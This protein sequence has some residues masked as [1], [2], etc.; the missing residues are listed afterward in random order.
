[1]NSNNKVREMRQSIL[2]RCRFAAIAA[3]LFTMLSLP[4]IA[5]NSLG[6]ISGVARDSASGKAV[7]E[8]KI[9]I[10]EMRKN[11]ESTAVSGANGA[12]VIALEPGWYEVTATRNGFL[13]YTA[14]IRVDS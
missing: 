13:K 5:Q 1:M 3:F 2:S 12:F 6:G 9:T 7:A 10:H 11:T 4:A 8:A 14:R